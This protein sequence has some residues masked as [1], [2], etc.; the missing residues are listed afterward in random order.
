M[1]VRVATPDYFKAL[2]IP[3]TRGRL[4]TDADR[5]ESPQVV[6]L[7]EAAA[8]EY[9]PSEN[10]LGRRIVLGWNIDQRRAG[11]EVVG[12]VGDVK[13]LG[14]DE[15]APA[16]I[17]LPHAQMG[18]GQMTMIL[19]SDVPTASLAALVTRTV[20]GLDPNLPISSLRSLD[21]I[22]A[23]SVSQ[24]RFYM[25]LLGTFAVAALLL[26]AI[27][28]FGV[29]SYAVTQQTRE[30]GIRIALGADRRAIVRM[31]LARAMLLITLGLALGVAG[32]LVVGR[33]MSTLLFDVSPQDPVTLLAVVSLLAGVAFLASYL[34]ARRATRVDPMVALRAD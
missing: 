10:P 8:R 27:G 34:P 9:F 21:A 18:V 11:G 16:E 12:V 4:F 23:R 13:D 3:L 29:M 32:A 28:I 1:Q 2:G 7:S 33:A 20:H 30:F 26:A 15:P 24:P 17:Y 6:L 14:L 31:V 25:L 5:F 22:I 19:R